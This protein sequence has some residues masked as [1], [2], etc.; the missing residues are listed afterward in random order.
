[1]LDSAR[2]GG[3]EGGTWGLVKEVA[4]VTS[5]ANLHDVHLVR[6]DGWVE[7]GCWCGGHGVEGLEGRWGWV[8]GFDRSNSGATARG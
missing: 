3:S 6:A 4:D 2:E 5:A 1:M 8:R 7:S